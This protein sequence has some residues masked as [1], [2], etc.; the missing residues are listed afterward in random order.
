MPRLVL[1]SGSRWRRQLLDRL[2][3]PYAWA[4]PDIDETPHP[5]EAPEPLVHRLA[6]AKAS[7]VAEEYPDHLVIGS[8]QVAT[9]D[10]DILGKPGDEA[11]ARAQ[12][13]RFSGH[14]VTFFTGLAL[15]DTRNAR[16]WVCHE[17]YDA[18]FRRLSDAEIARYVEREQPLD[19]AGSFR[20]EGLGIALFEKLEGDD[21]NTLIG[22]PLIRLCQLLREAGLDPLGAQGN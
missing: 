21:P 18:C 14:R 11:T 22:L 2:G 3:L 8:D 19:S 7:R 10:G 1:A 13:A 16:H 9:F 17:R 15:I 5:G 4:S 12:L 6:L 20:M